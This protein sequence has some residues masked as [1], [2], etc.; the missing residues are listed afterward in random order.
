MKKTKKEK[1][2]QQRSR[3]HQMKYMYNNE[4]KIVF[5]GEIWSLFQSREKEMC[6]LFFFSYLA[7]FV[8]VS[9]VLC[10][11][12][13]CVRSLVYLCKTWK[14][15]HHPRDVSLGRLQGISFNFC[16][17]ND[18]S[19]GPDRVW[20]ECEKYYSGKGGRAVN[21]ICGK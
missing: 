9:S 11:Q 8:A 10:L 15:I 1:K 19:S 6:L 13:E 12:C 5:H 7:F 16:L 18:D 2:K 3:D 20:I 21:A 14:F 4:I 17:E